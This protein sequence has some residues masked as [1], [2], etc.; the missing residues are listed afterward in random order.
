MNFFL[1]D[2]GSH[3]FKYVVISVGSFELS[4]TFYKIKQSFDT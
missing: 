2:G 4:K 3:K 1:Q